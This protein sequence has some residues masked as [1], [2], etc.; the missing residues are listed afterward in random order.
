MTKKELRIQIENDVA[1][2]LKT[3]PITK[4][5]PQK[6]PK[7]ITARAHSKSK[8]ISRLNRK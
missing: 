1:E 5:R 7:T 8:Y 2:F 4:L 6:T 3:K